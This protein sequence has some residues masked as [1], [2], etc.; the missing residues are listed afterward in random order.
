[1]NF[2]LQGNLNSQ[3]KLLVQ[4]TLYVVNAKLQEPPVERRVF[5]FETMII[6]CEPFERKT[7]LRAYMYRHSIEVGFPFFL[8]IF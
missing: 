7:N 4:D 3:G 1:M 6:F 2:Y 5:L 8:F